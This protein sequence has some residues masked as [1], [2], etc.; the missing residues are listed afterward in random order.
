MD[1]LRGSADHHDGQWL[2]FQGTDLVATLDLRKVVSISSVSG[3]F[4]QHPDSQILLPTGVEVAVSKNGRKYKTMYAAPVV[5]TTEAI[6]VVKA[7]FR[8]TNARYVRVTARNA[9][10]GGDA[11]TW[12]FADE[13]V[14]E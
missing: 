10:K 7:T 5:P 9:Q 8:K 6:S 3:T 14:V 1:G 13:L 11:Q 4:L 12:L 2:G